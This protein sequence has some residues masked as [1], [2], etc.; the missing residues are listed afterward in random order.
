MG[1]LCLSRYRH[2]W[3]I[4]LSALLLVACNG[5]AGPTALNVETP[6]NHITPISTPTLA[7]EQGQDSCILVNGGQIE[8]RIMQAG[9]PVP[10]GQAVNIIFTG[11]PTEEAFTQHGQYT[12]PLLAR[13]C[14]NK[15]AWVGLEFWAGNEAF[16]VLPNSTDYHFDLNLSSAALVGASGSPECVLTLGTIG[17]KIVKGGETVPDGTEVSVRVGAGA[18]SEGLKVSEDPLAQTVFTGGGQYQ[19]T[20]IGRQCD[21]GKQFWGPVR[22]AAFGVS[23]LVTP[24]QSR[25]IQDVIVP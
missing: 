22:I 17:G 12:L 21:N 23:V 7:R 16:Q 4:L 10:D 11:G 3:M 24:T 18:T 2:S 5:G 25:A 19:A 6:Q 1:L 13:K 20:L 8:G 15:L 14:G 9:I